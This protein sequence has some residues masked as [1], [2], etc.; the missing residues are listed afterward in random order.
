MKKGLLFFA[1]LILSVTISLKGQEDTQVLLV[2][3]ELTPLKGEKSLNVV[4]SYDNM[5][6]G[7]LPS[8][9]AYIDKKVKEHNDAFP[10]KGDKWLAEWNSNKSTLWEP[11]FLIPFNKA[12]KKYGVVAEKNATAAKYTMLV[13]TTFL[14]IGFTGWSYAKKDAEVELDITVYEG[15]DRES[16]IAKLAV[17]NIYGKQGDYSFTSGIRISSAYEMAGK[18]LGK[19]IVQRVYK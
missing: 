19:F 9:S 3:G 10:G 1:L 18:K 15:S 6:V 11:G 17:K 4:F 5:V 7:I 14:E 2:S 8:E 16:A 13:S 12:I